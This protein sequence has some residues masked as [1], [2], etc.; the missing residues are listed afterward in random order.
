L[1]PEGFAG[2][3]EAENAPED[4]EKQKWLAGIISAFAM[5]SPDSREELVEALVALGA[6]YDEM[7]GPSG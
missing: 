6:P 3:I 5:V 7:F 4:P 2:Y 1:T